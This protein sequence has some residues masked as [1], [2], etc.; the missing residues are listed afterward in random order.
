MG[1]R[2]FPGIAQLGHG[3][4]HPPPSIAEVKKKSRAILLLHLW[5]FMPGYRINLTFLPSPTVYARFMY[6]SVTPNKK[7]F[8]VQHISDVNLHVIGWW[9]LPPG[10][11]L[12]K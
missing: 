2:L 7:Q 6:L 1:T 11:T 10:C 5:V 3:I 12:T 9:T 8:S 4:N